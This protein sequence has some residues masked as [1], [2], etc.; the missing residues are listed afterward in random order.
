VNLVYIAPFAFSP[1]AT[2]SARMLPMA[3][4]LVRRGHRVTILMPPYDNPAD[5][6][7]HWQHDGV[8]L[9]NTGPGGYLG[10][11]RH[12][13]ARARAL[14]PDVIHVF[15]PIG[16]GALTL[17]AFPK[18]V[19][20][21]DDWE[22]AGGWLDINPYTPLQKRVF[23][24][25]EQH[26]LRHSP[27][28]TCA[29]EALVER[30]RSFRT[31]RPGPLLLLP[32]GPNA[33]TRDEVTEAEPQREALRQTFGWADKAVLIYTGT[34]P[35]NHDLDVMLDAVAGLQH[36]YTSLRLVFV[37]TG[38]GIPS[39]KVR[40]TRAGLDDITE[41]HGFMPHRDML[42]RL[43]AADIALYPYRDTP[44][45]RAKCSGKVMD[46]MASA[47]PMV[48]SDVG[49]NRV[50]TRDGESAWLTP[51]GDVAAFRAAI[52]R[53]LSD[54][55]A[56]QAMGRAA[57]HRIWSVF[58]WGERIEALERLYAHQQKPVRH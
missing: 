6:N 57:Q 36:V 49:M 53:I 7:K 8:Q 47:K 2:V 45:N 58:G 54:P 51:H 25:Q 44:I 1:K 35:L 52:E 37:A 39:V 27:A 14:T 43:V 31:G 22:G 56:A 21:N 30:T 18:A 5:A 4:A 34:I 10:M 33:R 42:A 40:V 16:V 24:W 29:S 13:V 20:D 46:Y 26:W 23:A 48:L 55:G 50:Y 17:H 11:A 28:V 9:E 41:W 38:D 32:N 19:L 15:K 12:L 3:S